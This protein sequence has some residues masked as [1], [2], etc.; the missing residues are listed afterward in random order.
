MWAENNSSIG[1]M[2]MYEVI[3]RVIK[4]EAQQNKSILQEI[5][6]C[7]HRATKKR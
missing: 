5:T 6:S 4:P 7:K 1:R 3:K 2:L